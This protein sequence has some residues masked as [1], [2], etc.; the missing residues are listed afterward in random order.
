M[1]FA[2]Q[3][4]VVIDGADRSVY[5]RGCQSDIRQKVNMFSFTFNNQ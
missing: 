5:L 2:M 3:R 4:N 1:Y